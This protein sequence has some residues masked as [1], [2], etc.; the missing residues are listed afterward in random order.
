MAIRDRN[1]EW[2]RQKRVIPWSDFSLIAADGGTLAGPGTGA[3]VANAIS[4]SG[5]A[6]LSMEVSDEASAFDFQ[7]PSTANIHAEIGVRVLYTIDVATPA[8][9]DAVTWLVKYDQV[10]PGEAIIKPATALD[11]AVAAQ[12]DGDTTGLLYRVSSRGIIDADSV[13]ITAKTGVFTWLIEADAVTTYSAGEITLLGLE[14]DYE[15]ELC[16]TA[17]ETETVYKDIAATN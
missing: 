8:A 2:K 13:D 17:D 16:V 6:G 5:L 12:A 14:I 3:P 11:T 4:T 1:I 7:T 10:D 9:T 15:L